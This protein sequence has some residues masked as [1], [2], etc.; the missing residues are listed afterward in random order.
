M[1]NQTLIMMNQQ[2][3]LSILIWLLLPNPTIAGPVAASVGMGLVSS[4]LVY[5]APY[6]LATIGIPPPVSQFVLTA[7]VTAITVLP[8]P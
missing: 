7:V 3:I 8:T 4:F 1:M 5:V 6:P 2:Q